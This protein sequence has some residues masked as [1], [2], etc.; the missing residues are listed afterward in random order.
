MAVKYVQGGGGGILSNLGDL[1]SLGGLVIPGAGW[2]TALGLGMRATDNMINKRGGGSMT[3]DDLSKLKDIVNGAGWKNPASGNV[4]KVENNSV[5]QT[6]D[7]E[8]YARG[9]GAW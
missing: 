5:S 8:L 3:V 1:A 9:W 2:L 4:A 7:D 6:S